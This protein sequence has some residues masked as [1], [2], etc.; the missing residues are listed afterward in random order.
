MAR[1]RL[2]R[3]GGFVHDIN[4]VASLSDVPNNIRLLSD[5]SL[6][7]LQNLSLED[8]TFL[9]RY[10][11]IL[12]GD[13][14]LPV[15]AG[16]PEESDVQDAVDLIRRDLNSMGV[17][18]LLECLCSAIGALVEQGAVAG[19]V[20]GDIASDGT[21]DYGPGEQFP[22][23]SSYFDAK[24]N[25]ANGIYDTILGLVDWLDDNDV[26]LIAGLFGGVTSGLL[27]AIAL[28]GPVGWAWAV[29]GGLVAG[30]AGYIV[31]LSVNFSDLSAAL[32]DTHDECV[33]GLYNA[34][35]A[36]T[37]KTSFIDAVE[38]GTPVITSA[39]SG[40]LGMLL[41]SD[42][43][44]N[45]FAP[46][47]DIVFYESPSPVDCGSA[48]LASWTFP[49]DAEG[50][51]FRD[52]SAGASSAS[53]IW[54][55]SDLALQITMNNAGGAS[56]PISKGTWLETG[57]AIAVPVSSSVQFD[58]SA[59]SDGIN[60]SKHIKIIYDDLSESNKTV[61]GGTTAGTLI[62]TLPAA[63]TIEEIECSISRTTSVM[64]SHTSD[65]LEVRVIGT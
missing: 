11:E 62:I 59:P 39:E 1:R 64:N 14:Y 54:N 30:L 10:G 38:A 26:G 8:V 23:Q 60:Q 9:S 35:N 65:I 61:T 13:F 16:A 17:E 21:V 5:R 29:V 2:S 32:G 47:E 4:T 6:Y 51:V 15:V 34:S 31:E 52:D 57:L 37:A 49:V 43:V 46:R 44:N 20:V 18:A 19:Q 42:L 36:A 41:S 24:C 58:Y 56:K 48:I 28:S 55:S 63:K 3:V 33:L 12:T 45:L 7:I 40:L 22:D 27:V 25:V 53:G 50:W